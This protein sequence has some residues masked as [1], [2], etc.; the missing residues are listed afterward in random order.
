[1]SELQRPS[2]REESLL[3][4]EWLSLAHIVA[5]FRD[6]TDILAFKPIREDFD[7]FFVHTDERPDSFQFIEKPR[8]PDALPQQFEVLVGA[9]YKFE[10]KVK[11]GIKDKDWD[12]GVVDDASGQAHMDLQDELGLSE[13][14]EA[15]WA[16]FELLQR[17]FFEDYTKA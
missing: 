16:H 7:A 9:D 17:S 3:S 13:A 10:L 8:I 1:M 4:S 15:D 14:N 11:I 2:Q 12:N 5:K 6:R